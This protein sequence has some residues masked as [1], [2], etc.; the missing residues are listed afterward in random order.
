MACPNDYTISVAN[1]YTELKKYKPVSMSTERRLIR[2][3]KRGN[4]KAKKELIESNLRF[5]FNIAK[6]YTGRG[7]SIGDLISEG[8]IGMIKAI[9]KFDETKGNR[10][11]SY[12]IWWIRQ[13]MLETIS[14]Q[15]RIILTEDTIPFAQDEDATDQF[16]DDFHFEPYK[17]DKYDSTSLSYTIDCYNKE[18][19]V[20]SKQKE[21]IDE[22]L[23]VLSSKE[24]EII[25]SYFG[26]NGNPSMYLFEIGKKYDL[27]SERV[28]QIKEKA[29]RKL[30]SQM[31][32]M[33]IDKEDLF[34]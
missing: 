29:I 30:R 5:V 3:C 10:F 1:Y 26:I 20:D 9:D 27:S 18:N 25:E 24:R 31:L 14:K 19:E 16:G 8:N 23:S 2:L 13:A 17:N 33:N 28:R 22:L 7:I 21:T 34:I 11:I 32:I 4:E 15:S 12:A 6:K